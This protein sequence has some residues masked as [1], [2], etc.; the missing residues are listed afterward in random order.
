MIQ[1]AKGRPRR[2]RPTGKLNLLVALLQ[3]RRAF[4]LAN[5]RDT[6]IGRLFEQL[7]DQEYALEFPSDKK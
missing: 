5:K 2:K 3:K 6:S 4:T 7:I 1:R